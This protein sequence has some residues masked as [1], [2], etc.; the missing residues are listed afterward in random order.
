MQIDYPQL[1]T[2]IINSMRRSNHNSISHL[3]SEVQTAKDSNSPKQVVDYYLEIQ[4]TKTE[5]TNLNK[6]L[7]SLSQ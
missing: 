3:S 1:K 6:S 7:I 2:F 4:K 5:N